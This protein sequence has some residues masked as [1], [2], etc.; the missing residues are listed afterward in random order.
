MPSKEDFEIPEGYRE[1]V[2]YILGKSNERQQFIH[3]VIADKKVCLIVATFFLLHTQSTDIHQ[4]CDACSNW[5]QCGGSHQPAHGYKCW[6]CRKRKVNCPW[7]RSFLVHYT[8]VKFQLSQEDAEKAYRVCGKSLMAIND[9]GTSSRRKKADDIGRRI[10]RG[11]AVQM[12]SSSAQD[13]LQET[14]A[15][16]NRRKRPGVS[17]EEREPASIEGPNP[18]KKRKLKSTLAVRTPS[19]VAVTGNHASTNAAPSELS[20][21]P[22]SDLS[23]SRT[24][25][26]E[27][28]TPPT[29]NSSSLPQ[30][31]IASPTAD[32]V[33]T[34]HSRL[35]TANSH[36]QLLQ[37]QQLL[38]TA[39]VARVESERDMLKDV[40]DGLRRTIAEQV[41]HIAAV[42]AH[43]DDVPDALPV[44]LVSTE[45]QTEASVEERVQTPT[46][47]P[48]SESGPDGTS[49]LQT[50]MRWIM[51]GLIDCDVELE[52]M[53]NR[54]NETVLV[55]E[56]RIEK[57]QEMLTKL[58]RYAVRAIA[59]AT[60]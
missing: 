33:Q 11:G 59:S 16:D 60:A 34:L 38:L 25:E 47:A 8:A 17:V 48:R 56:A 43:L 53:R 23:S 58:E 54:P 10:T 15:S 51:N 46:V 6:S 52:R 27:P 45:V 55:R 44:S 37:Q 21:S 3:G 7:K 18:S 50:H 26:S 41:R 19:L 32:L 24:S 29:P 20:S 30:L 36:I 49:A 14:D 22:L 1:Y 28:S 4:Y 40:E 57:V 39:H 31:S 42:D 2:Q 5:E 9:D 13:T 35:S 12:A